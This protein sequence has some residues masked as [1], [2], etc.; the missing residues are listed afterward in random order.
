MV[1]KRP[2]RV[3]RRWFQPSPRAGDRQRVCSAA[4][5]Q[6]ERH[7]RACEQWRERHPHY[8]REERVRRRVRPVQSE[9]RRPARD[10][11]AEVAWEAARDVVGVEA[12]V[13][14]E[15]TAKVLH[16]Y[17]RDAVA[18]QA[19]VITCESPR[20]TRAGPRDGFA[21]GGDAA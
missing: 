16:L 18:G 2:C 17:V 19:T 3:C 21:D 9:D 15:E 5:C 12:S 4:G 1:R 10:P 8:D 13:L 20:E 7:R 11:V 14:I 6:R